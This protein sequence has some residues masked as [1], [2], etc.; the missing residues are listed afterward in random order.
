MTCKICGGTGYLKADPDDEDAVEVNNRHYK[1]CS[2]RGEICN[3]NQS[4]FRN[5]IPVFTV[6]SDII[7]LK[8]CINV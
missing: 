2:C 1:I 7:I 3:K 5:T 8:R 4:E 6:K